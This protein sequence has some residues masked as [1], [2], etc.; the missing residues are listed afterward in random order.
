V[1]FFGQVPLLKVDDQVIFESLVIT[2]FIEEIS[3]HSFHPKEAIQRAKV[4]VSGPN[5]QLDVETLKNKTTKE[6]ERGL[7]IILNQARYNSTNLFGS[8]IRPRLGWICI[9]ILY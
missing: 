8:E 5:E 6:V 1:L 3:T 4:I 7:M 9:Y 2:E